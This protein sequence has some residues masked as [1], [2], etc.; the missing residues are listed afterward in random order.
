MISITYGN[1]YFSR[2]ELL[3]TSLDTFR[4]IDMF[5]LNKANWQ[6]VYFYFNEVPIAEISKL[7][8]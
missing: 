3:S 8:H 7:Y 1:L 2:Y 4:C 5:S 6:N